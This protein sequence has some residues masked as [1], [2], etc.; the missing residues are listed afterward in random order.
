[1]PGRRHH[2][3][4]AAREQIFRP[5]H[6]G[7]VHSRPGAFPAGCIPGR[8][9]SRPVHPRPVHP[10]PVHPRPGR[11]RG[12]HTPS[13]PTLRHTPLPPELDPGSGAGGADGD[14]PGDLD[15][16]GD[17]D[18]TGAEGDGEPDGRRPDVAG[19]GNADGLGDLAPGRPGG[20]GPVVPGLPGSAPLA[21]RLPGSAVRGLCTA[22]RP[23]LGSTRCGSDC[24]GTNR[25]ENETSST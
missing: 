10:R 7:R 24:G 9:H 5:L 6:P 3:V 17:L 22:P 12:T 14:G 4:T 18:G 19:E 1:M 23:L 20:P 11:Y 8:V 16:S 2:S 21:G 25:I 15:G 13:S